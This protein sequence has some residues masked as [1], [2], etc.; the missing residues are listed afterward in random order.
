MEQWQ[1]VKLTIGRPSVS[2]HGICDCDCDWEGGIGWWRRRG[3]DR[4]TGNQGQRTCKDEH[5]CGSDGQKVG[6][7][8]SP[9]IPN[10]IITLPYR[11]YPTPWPSEYDVLVF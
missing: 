10:H 5:S 9:E 4:K 11:I 2:R 6:E 7:V 8:L 1:W 3:R